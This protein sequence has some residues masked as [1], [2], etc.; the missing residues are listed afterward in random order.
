MRAGLIVSGV[1]GLG[2]AA[3]FAAALVVG[4]LFPNGATIV[5]GTPWR[6]GVIAQG[7]NGMMIDRAGPVFV[8]NGTGG[9][10]SVME[11]PPAITAPDDGS[12][13]MSSGVAPEASPGG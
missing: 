4:T 3:T 7:I 6:G 13:P 12:V 8:G 1:L 5:A 9:T 2:T 11:S 10:I